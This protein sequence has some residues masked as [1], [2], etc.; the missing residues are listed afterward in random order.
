MIVEAAGQA[1]KWYR[2]CSLMLESRSKRDDGLL[3]TYH[4]MVLFPIKLGNTF[5]HVGSHLI[6]CSSPS[7][8]VVC[9]FT[10]VY[11]CTCECVSLYLELVS[12]SVTLCSTLAGRVFP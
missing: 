5:S 3:N 11:I 4:S 10:F 7:L 9:V 2:E 6:P 12:S 8:H 1:D